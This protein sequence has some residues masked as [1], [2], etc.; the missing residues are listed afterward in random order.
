MYSPSGVGGSVTQQQ[1]LQSVEN[2]FFTRTIKTVFLGYFNAFDL[3]NPL[4]YCLPVRP[5]GTW[6]EKEFG[7]LQHIPKLRRPIKH[8]LCKW[9]KWKDFDVFFAGKINCRA[10]HLFAVALAFVGGLYFGVVDDDPFGAS[11]D[12][13]HLSLDD[14]FVFDVEVVKKYPPTLAGGGSCRSIVPV[15]LPEYG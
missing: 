8:T 14:A 10:D 15:A 6:S 13:S 5:A 12:E 7:C 4:V 1:I 3:T 9:A 2:K 11:E